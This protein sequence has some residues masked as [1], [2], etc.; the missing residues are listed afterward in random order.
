MPTGTVIFKD[1][2]TTLGTGTLSTLNGVTTATFSTG[3]LAVGSHSITATYSGDLNFNASTAAA[4]NEQIR[5]GTGTSTSLIT[6]LNPSYY[7]QQVS[8]IATVS[9]GA[10]GSP[11][12]TGTVTFKDGTKTLG[13][14]VLITT[15]GVTK[16]IFA[17]SSLAVG[18]HS[19]TAVYFGDLNFNAST[20]AAVLENVMKSGTGA[21]L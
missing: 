15:N 16:A 12:P 19:I 8:F 17:T 21:S 6:S 13:T 1:G 5:A 9:V 11:A 14:A 7:G 2:S 3:S 18:R 20:S 4:V 10:P